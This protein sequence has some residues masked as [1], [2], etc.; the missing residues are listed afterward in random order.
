M[1]VGAQS[2]RSGQKTN[3]TG[4]QTAIHNLIAR[5]YPGPGGEVY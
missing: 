1:V 5:S 4:R 2:E 3:S